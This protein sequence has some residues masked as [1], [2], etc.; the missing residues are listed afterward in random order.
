MA[1]PTSKRGATGISDRSGFRH[2]LRD[3]IEEPG[4]KYLIHPKESDGM[5]NKVTHPLNRLGEDIR[6][7]DPKP[8]RNPSPPA[9]SFEPVV[10]L[11]EGTFVS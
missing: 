10:P 8:V 2:P 4:T 5:Y 9:Y 3:M 11:T 1:K 6:F 7:D